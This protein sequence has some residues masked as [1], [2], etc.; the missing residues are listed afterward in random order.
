MPK[1]QGGNKGKNI[2]WLKHFGAQTESATGPQKEAGWKGM[3]AER[4]PTIPEILA[5][6]VKEE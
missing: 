4:E 2:Y 1:F 6:E 3:K 5:P